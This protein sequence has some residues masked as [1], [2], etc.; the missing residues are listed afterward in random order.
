MLRSGAFGDKD[1]IEP[2]SSFKWHRLFLMV[3]AQHVAHIFARGAYNYREDKGMNLP[4]DI[5]NAVAEILQK[6][7]E[8]QEREITEQEVRFSSKILNH[9]LK[10]IIN[11]E[12]HNIDTSVESLDLLEI[13]IFNITSMLNNGISLDGI[14][15]LG[16]YLRTRGDKV[17]FVKIETWIGQLHI[18]KMAQLQGCILMAVFGF[19]QDEIPFVKTIDK[20]AF[21]LTVRSVSLLA[22]D[23]AKDWEAGQKERGFVRSNSDMLRKNLR[24]SMKYYSYAPM[25]TTSTFFTNL[26]RSLSEIE[27]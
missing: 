1:A 20:K 6:E 13:I 14:I 10:R 23:T 21:E 17:D 9:K 22:K 7:K 8:E 24:R 16:K 19:E 25:E 5:A 12:L 3:E 18:A 4:G 27:E 15:K 26:G 11:S 2:M